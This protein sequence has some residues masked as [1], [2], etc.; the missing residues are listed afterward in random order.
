MKVILTMII[1]SVACISCR[2]PESTPELRDPVYLDMQKRLSAQ[3]KELKAATD[4]RPKIQEDLTK[5]NPQSGEY[6]ARWREYYEN[7]KKIYL[8][9][10][11]VSYFKM[12]IDSRRKAARLSYLEFYKNNKESEW[13]DPND[14]ARYKSR[15]DN[16]EYLKDSQ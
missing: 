14:F 12:S 8:T 5:L 15:M 1:I 3:E 13:P 7:E 6:K 9:E 10:Q 4:E 2:K 11:K 16:N